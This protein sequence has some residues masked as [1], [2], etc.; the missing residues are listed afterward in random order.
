MEA[1]FKIARKTRKF[2]LLAKELTGMHMVI[3]QLRGV[4]SMRDKH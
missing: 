4:A 2:A 1:P 3:Q